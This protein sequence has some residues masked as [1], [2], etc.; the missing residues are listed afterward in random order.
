M[1]KHFAAPPAQW[2]GDRSMID[3]KH[4]APLGGDKRSKKK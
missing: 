3:L 4:R 2:V 1:A